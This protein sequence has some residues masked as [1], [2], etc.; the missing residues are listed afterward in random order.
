MELVSGADGSILV[1]IVRPR[2]QTR[3]QERLQTRKFDVSDVGDVENGARRQ[4]VDAGQSK[5]LQTKCRI[6]RLS[7]QS[8]LE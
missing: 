4:D 2:G 5:C 7:E 1:D 3:L 6:K 8:G